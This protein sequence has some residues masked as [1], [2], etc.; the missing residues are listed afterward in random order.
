MLRS[1]LSPSQSN[2]ERLPTSSFGAVTEMIRVSF[3]AS[4]VDIAYTVDIRYFL[5]GN[6]QINGHVQCCVRLWSEMIQ[7]INIVQY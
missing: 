3:L 5:Q 2:I 4:Q 6:H 7:V 1:W